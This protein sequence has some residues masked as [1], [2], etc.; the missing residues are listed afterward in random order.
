MDTNEIEVFL[1][2]AD[3]LHFGRTAERLRLPQPQVSRL[4]AR[5][6]RRAGGALFDR[7]NRRVRLTPLGERLR[8]RLG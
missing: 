2:L 7:T 4:V 8:G 1:V 6:E 3:E 5:L